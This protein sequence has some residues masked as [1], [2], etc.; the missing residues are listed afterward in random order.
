MLHLIYYL[1]CLHS[2]EDVRLQN[3]EAFELSKLQKQSPDEILNHYYAVG[4]RQQ[5]N[6]IEEESDELVDKSSNE[7]ADEE[8]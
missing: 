7:E 6:V 3:Q 1:N 5:S 2:V 4:N 8:G